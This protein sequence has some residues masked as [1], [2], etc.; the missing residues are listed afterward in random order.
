MNGRNIIKRNLTDL[1]DMFP[2]LLRIIITIAGFILL[3]LQGLKEIMIYLLCIYMYLTVSEIYQF[4]KWIINII[5]Y[6]LLILT[7][8]T[9]A[10]VSKGYGVLGFA[11][12]IVAVSC[13]KLFGTKE[14][15]S[16]YFNAMA[17]IETLVFGK[18]LNK[19]NWKKEK[20]VLRIKLKR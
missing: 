2:N 4:K 17:K 9:F 19:D 15:R 7:I 10:F 14:G 18:S 13:L 8:Y 12:F 5:K 11:L 16:N 3:E 6:V 1:K 20:P